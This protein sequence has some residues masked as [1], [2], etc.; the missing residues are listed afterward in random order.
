MKGR[1]A[2]ED[3]IVTEMDFYDEYPGKMEDVD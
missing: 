1:N 3:A 2:D